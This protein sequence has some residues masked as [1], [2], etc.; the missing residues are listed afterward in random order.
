[1]KDLEE[2]IVSNAIKEIRRTKNSG[3]ALAYAE[4]IR[5]QLP[6]LRNPN[7]Y[8]LELEKALQSAEIRPRMRTGGVIVENPNASVSLGVPV[9]KKGKRTMRKYKNTRTEGQKTCNATRGACARIARG[10]MKATAM[11]L[12]I[13]FGAAHLLSKQKIPILPYKGYAIVSQKIKDVHL[14][15]WD[16]LVAAYRKSKSKKAWNELISLYIRTRPKERRAMLEALEANNNAKKAL[17]FI[18]HGFNVKN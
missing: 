2:F 6:K 15:K 4:R 1:M 8:A 16:K 9:E 7:V 10:G 5:K 17:E 14:Q 13:P 3:T 12:S 18:A 11:T